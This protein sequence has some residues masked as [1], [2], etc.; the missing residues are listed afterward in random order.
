M[1]AGHVTES[2]E[3]GFMV[4]NRAFRY[5]YDAMP[6]AYPVGAMVTTGFSNFNITSGYFSIAATEH[7]I[8][9][10]ISGANELRF[11]PGVFR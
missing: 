8:G 10:E 4:S 1:Q 2:F 6:D 3:K 11:F 9:E 5:F 7:N